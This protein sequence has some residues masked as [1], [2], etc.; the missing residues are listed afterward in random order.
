MPD[1]F[2]Q[3]F[4][5][6]ALMAGLLASVACGIIGVYIIIKRMVFISGG[7]AH[8]SFGGIGLGYYWSAITPIQGALM[9]AL[10]SSLGIGVITRKTRLT[11]DTAIGIFWSMGMAS[12]SLLMNL[13]SGYPPDPSKYLFGNILLVS[14]SALLLILILDAII[15]ALVMALYKEFLALCFDE[16]YATVIGMPVT[17]LYLLLLSMIGLTVVLLIRVV[18]IVLV[19]ALL[20]IPAAMARQ[21]TYDLRKMMLIA[22]GLGMVFTS[23]GLWLSYE[24]DVV[25]S[26][27]T[28]ILLAGAVFFIHLGIVRLRN[29]AKRGTKHRELG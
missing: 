17:V 24:I 2:Q 14:D 16:E 7:V 11:E 13:G 12:G 26:G 8:A 28:I 23:G 29:M 15:I 3:E 27:A 25:S 21:F 9:F 10:G 5:Q 18:G 19:I 22:I 6:N 4:M 1:V 20:T